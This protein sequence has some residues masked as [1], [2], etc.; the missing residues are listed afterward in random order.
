[1]KFPTKKK[2]GDAVED[3][4]KA[5]IMSVFKDKDVKKAIRASVSSAEITE[6]GSPPKG[7]V[8]KVGSA[9][10]VAPKRQ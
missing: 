10:Y 9:P 2:G 4:S 3:S 6:I 5:Y 8:K 7:V 1:M